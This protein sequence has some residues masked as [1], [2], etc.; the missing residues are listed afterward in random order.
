MFLKL[1]DEDDIK[2]CVEGV[3]GLHYQDGGFTQPLNKQYKVKQNQQT[4]T[5]PESVRKYL[6]DIFYENHYIDSVYCPSRVSVNFY[7]KYQKDD[8]YDIHVDAFKA[9]PKSNNVF[10]DYGFSINL[11]DQYEGGEF[12]IHT[13]VGPVARKLEAGEAVIFPIIYPHGVTKVTSGI[14]E[15]ILGWFSTNVS[16]EQAFI[17]KNLYDVNTHLRTKDTEVF[18]KS[19]LVQMYLKKAWGK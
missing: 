7:N 9:M 3:Q 15:N 8:Y 12:L 14:R 11:N 18:V 17:L 10:F 5:V 2:Y 6:I 4:S 13:D 19:T 16:Y 1:L